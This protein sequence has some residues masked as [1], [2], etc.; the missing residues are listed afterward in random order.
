MIQGRAFL[1]PQTPDHGGGVLFFVH[2]FPLLEIRRAMERGVAILRGLRAPRA[3]QTQHLNIT[4]FLLR[5]TN[6]AQ[7]FRDRRL[8]FRETTLAKQSILPHRDLFAA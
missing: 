7:Q 4:D 5:T 8:L 3:I 1:T 6:S 2:R